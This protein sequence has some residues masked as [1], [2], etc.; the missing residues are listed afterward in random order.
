[1]VAVHGRRHPSSGIIFTSDSV[2]TAS[3]ALRREEEITVILAP[4][5]KTSARLVGRDPNTDLAVLRLAQPVEAPAPRW[6]ETANLRVGELV[7]AAARTWRGNLVASS[8]ILSGL[9][10]P[11]RAWRGGEIEQFI[12]P[13]LNFYPG[14]SG[15]ALINSLGQFLGMNTTGLHRSGITIPAGTVRR[16]AAEL[17]EKGRVERPW[18]G[19]AMQAVPLPES[20]RTRL[21]L[22]SSEAL[23]VAHVEPGSAAEKAGILLGD[24]LVELEGKPVADTEAV[25]RFLH[26]HRA[27]DRIPVKLVRGG[28]ILSLDVTLGTRSK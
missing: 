14:F 6:G 2:V 18:L 23:L 19:L 4:G 24:V 1:V 5:T 17:L 13:D 26:S 21:N 20:L 3:H 25:Q 10:G 27:G 12:R 28:A 11:W 7:V 16:V 15:G 22:I 8:G 9:M